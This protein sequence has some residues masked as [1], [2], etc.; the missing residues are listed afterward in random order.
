[1]TLCLAIKVADGIVGIADSRVTSG[2]ERIS[3]KKVTVLERSGHSMFLM[4]SGLRAIRDK[5]V[6][7]FEEAI[8]EQDQSFDKIY[9]VV[10]AFADQIRRVAEEDRDAIVASGMQF[11][12][13]ALVGGQLE[14][15]DE[16]RLYLL[17]PQ[18]N[19]VE[20]APGAPYFAIGESAYGKPILDRTLTYDTSMEDAL[21]IAYLAFDATR[22]S[23]TDVGFPLDVVVYKRDSY[24]IV[25]HRYERDDLRHVSEWWQLRV[26]EA[27]EEVPAEW[28]S[29]VFSKI[30]PKVVPLDQPGAS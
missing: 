1:V 2:T 20:V 4:T 11:D 30:R 8:A 26:R 7:Y 12:V 13:S 28:V 16:H 3:V 27:I 9:K 29:D 22:T 18:G 6:T 17:Y 23:A 21:K 24:H 5:A 14:R 10:N 15:D 19:W 25:E